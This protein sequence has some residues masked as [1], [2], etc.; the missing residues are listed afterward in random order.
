MKK[1]L[2]LFLAAT[3]AWGMTGCKQDDPVNPDPDPQPEPEP[4]PTAFVKKHLIEEFTGQDCGYC[5][6]GMDSVHAFVGDD[7]NW[8]VVL[9]HYGYQKDHFR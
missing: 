8:I 2:Y 7:P 6:M 4:L 3:L 1:F 9:H 5:P